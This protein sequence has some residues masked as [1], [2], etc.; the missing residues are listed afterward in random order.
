MNLCA[1]ALGSNLGHSRQTLQ[2]AIQTLSQHPL[3][4][5][6]K[7]SNWY[8]TKAVTCTPQ[9]DY[10]N[11]CAT[12]KTTLN[13]HALLALLLQVEQQYGRVRRG[14]WDARTLDLDLLLYG[15]L[16]I[17]TEQLTIPHPRMGDRSFVLIP[18]AEIAPDWLHPPT[19]DRIQTLANRLSTS[20]I[21]AAES[22]KILPKS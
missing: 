2:A 13:P 16:I 5:I 12:L 10:I 1:I 11:G 9:P 4:H 20:E 7:V 19:G 8:Q 15:E 17:E 21:I 3:I 14:K 6:L 18:L 22:H